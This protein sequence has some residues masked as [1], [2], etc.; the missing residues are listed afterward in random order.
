MK[1][2]LEEDVPTLIKVRERV[3]LWAGSLETALSDSEEE[4]HSDFGGEGCSEMTDTR[5]YILRVRR[6]GPLMSLCAAAESSFV[7]FL[8]GRVRAQF[9]Q[10]IALFLS[11]SS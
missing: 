5:S 1:E 7:E 9:S 11:F 6:I 8:G 10:G 2:Q 3:R 4:E